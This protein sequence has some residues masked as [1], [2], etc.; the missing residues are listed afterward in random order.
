M[1]C[2]VLDP[3]LE[4]GEGGGSGH[5][6]PS[7]R[8]GRALNKIFLALRASVCFKNKGGVRAPGSASGVRRELCK[9]TIFLLRVSKRETLSKT[10]IIKGKETGPL[11]E[12]FP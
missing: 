10:G 4:M 2:V 12:D 5:P 8:V 1:L 9:S 7:I 6:D 11:G 3:D